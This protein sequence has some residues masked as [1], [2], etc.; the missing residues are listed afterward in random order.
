MSQRLVNGDFGTYNLA[1]VLGH[2]TVDQGHLCTSIKINPFSKYK[3]FNKNVLNFPSSSQDSLYGGVPGAA[4]QM[5]E[6]ESDKWAFAGYATTDKSTLKTGLLDWLYDRPTAPNLR[7]YD[8]LWYYHYAPPCLMQAAGTRFAVDLVRDNP[9]TFPFYI[10]FRSGLQQLVNKKF[11]PGVGIG[12]ATA[13]SDTNDFAS[14]MTIEDL[15][16]NT[17]SVWG[18]DPYKLVDDTAG[19]TPCYLGFVLFPAT[20]NGVDYFSTVALAHHQTVQNDMFKINLSAMM[21]DPAISI[22][23]LGDYTAIACARWDNGLGYSYMPVYGNNSFPARFTMNLG[24][25]TNYPMEYIGIATAK[26]G[27]YQ[28]R[29]LTTT[30]WTVYIKVRMWNNS[31]SNMQI[32]PEDSSKRGK[33]ALRAGLNGS[34]T[35]VGS[36]DPTTITRTA[37]VSPGTS[38]NGD[39]AITISAGGST[40]IIYKIER[41]WD[42]DGTHSEQQLDQGQ[43]QITPQVSF[44]GDTSQGNFYPKKGG[45]L[46]VP[47]SITYG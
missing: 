44:M 38:E 2:C 45:G 7:R 27:P 46:Q 37:V 30:S 39:S 1:R 17:G 4:A 21:A 47:F 24:G 33:I 5:T 40:D 32:H 42:P 11:E 35:F 15:W 34:A 23:D 19:H 6:L 25:V 8:F 26:E 29:Y 3:P 28:E 43:L 20:G 41:I 10:L 16:A 18:N 22:L 9:G 13:V 12:S 14:C 36:Y 31:G